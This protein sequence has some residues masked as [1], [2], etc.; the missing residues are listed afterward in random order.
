MNCFFVALMKIWQIILKFSK[1]S[2]LK[3]TKG[4]LEVRIWLTI[5]S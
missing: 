5:F 4:V 3:V 2:N 1:K